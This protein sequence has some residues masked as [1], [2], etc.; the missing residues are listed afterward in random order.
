MLDQCTS[1]LISA[2]FSSAAFAPDAPTILNKER[3]LKSRYLLLNWTRPNDRGRHIF[4][5]WVWVR[6]LYSNSSKWKGTD[7]GKNLYYNITLEWASSFEFAVQ[8][9][10]DQGRGANSSITN[11]TVLPGE[12]SCYVPMLL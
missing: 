9:E 5:Y 12:G 6:T 1:F 7:A 11:F 2:R 3:Q 8:A 4:R 10:N